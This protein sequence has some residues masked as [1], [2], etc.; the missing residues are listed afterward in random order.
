[1][2]VQFWGT[3]GSVPTPGATTVRY[4]GNTSCVEIRAAD[5]T[6]VVL[7]CG[8]GAIPLG[9]AL[10]TEHP[11]PIRGALLIGHTHWDHI[12]GFPFFAP[13]FIPGNHW[14]VYGPGGLDR[15][16]AKG[17]AAQMAYEHFPVSINDLNATVQIRHLT[18]GV[19]EVGS[20]R[21]TTQYLNHPV[22]TLGYRLEADGVTVV[23]ATD[24]E[25]F[26]LYPLNAPRGTMPVH[27][28]DQRH[29]RFLEGADLVIHDAQYTL[30][31]FPAKTGWGHM[32]MEHA[33]DYAVLAGA[34][35]LALFHHDPSRDDKAIDRICKR[36]Q[37]RAAKSALQVDAASERR[38]IELLPQ[39]AR[40][41]PHGLPK[42]SALRLPATD[43]DGTVLI[44]DADT[45]QVRL[46]EPALHAEGLRVL[47][48][49]NAK[50]AL[51]LARQE[52][53]A[54]ILL[55][56][57]LP[58]VD[59]LTLCKTLRAEAEVCLSRVPILMLSREKLHETEIAQA[60]AAGAS[61]CLTIPVKPTLMRSRV[62]IWL[63]RMAMDS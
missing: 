24:F 40:V 3:R 18:E 8:T 42:A 22:F 10:L 6:L 44:A 48:A 51:R 12:Q 59:G 15:Q 31:E 20:I 58:G 11:D 45:D 26:S 2:R 23:Y 43:G 38:V 50:A 46:L 30:D 28:E 34:R 32:P 57:R 62:R 13:L 25:P 29:I 19:F 21:I 61:D 53:P 17:L 27:D 63:Q 16:I 60:F 41:S 4:G 14:E 5:G 39:S 56:M 37:T 9:R 49:A 54:V 1:M 52:Q 7:D 36:A 33:V 35:R 55:A 47:T